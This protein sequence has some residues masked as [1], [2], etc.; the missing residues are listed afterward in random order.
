MKFLYLSLIKSYSTFS[1]CLQNALGNFWGR[2]ISAEKAFISETPKGTSM[3]LTAS[4]ESQTS[5]FIGGFR[6][7][8]LTGILKKRKE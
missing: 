1:I 8:V 3:S 4:F 5:N 2:D 7:R 6:T